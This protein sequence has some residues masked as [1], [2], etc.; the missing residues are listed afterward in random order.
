MIDDDSTA[1][2]AA[3]RAA[4]QLRF[5]HKQIADLFERFGK[6]SR[7]VVGPVIPCPS[8]YGYRNRIMIRSQWNGPAKK[9]EIGFIRADNNFVVDIE[10]CKIAEP[11]LND[12]SFGG[13]LIWAGVRPFIDGR[14]DMYGD[15]FL[16][17]YARITAPEP[18]ALD[19][20]L[21]RYGIAW[22]IFPPGQRVTAMMDREPGW[23]R[24]YAD[25][26][27]VVHVRDEAPGVEG[28]RGGE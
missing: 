24:L 9:L 10:E 27:A 2:R 7:T 1:R 15:D 3:A 22:T 20:T 4:A 18:E 6:I 13:Y 5:K 8:P 17:R 11:V 21:Q 14:A 19:G 12:Y 25:K 16:G 28:L 23:R 26:F